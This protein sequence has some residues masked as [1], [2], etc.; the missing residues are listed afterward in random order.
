MITSVMSVQ[1][2]GYF[3]HHWSVHVPECSFLAVKNFPLNL[4][5]FLVNSGD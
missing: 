2:N 4:V 1:Q 5:S 3:T